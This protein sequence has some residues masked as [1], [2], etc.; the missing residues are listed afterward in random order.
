MNNRLLI[1]ESPTKAKT[2]KKFLGR[3]FTVPSSFG[4]IRDLPKSKMGVD[5][6]HDFAPHYIIPMKAK[7]TVTALKKDVEKA[8][9]VILATDSDREGEAIAWHLEQALNLKGKKIERI[10]FH[11][12]TKHAIDEAL[13]HPRELDLKLGDAQQA[14]RILD[15]LVGYELSPFLWKKFYRVLRRQLLFEP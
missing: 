10:A 1:V 11:E 9:T 12:I 4:H 13:A 6:E 5:T 2:I 8:D 3:D 7:K 14:R 15:R